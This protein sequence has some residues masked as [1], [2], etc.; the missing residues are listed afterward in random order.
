MP[1][2]YETTATVGDVASG[3]FT[4]LYNASG[5]NV[6]N[7]GGG[8]VSGNLNVAGNLTVQGTS[9]LQGAVILGSTL[10][11]P[12]YTMPS[13]DGST[14]Q[15]L[16]TDGSGNLYW[17]NVAAIPGAAYTIQ[18]DATTG[19]ANLTLLS[20]S[21]I[22]D[23]VKFAEGTNITIVQ[24]DANTIT[25]SSN[26]D[27]I[28]SG[29]A[30]GQLL[31]WNGTAWTA[32]NRISF[33]A[34]SARPA[35]INNVTGGFTAANFLKQY[36]G[37]LLDG[38]SVGTLWGATNGTTDTYTHR[39]LS[40]YDTGGNP[41]F[42]VQA[43]PVGNFNPS[44]PTVYTQLRLDNNYLGI[45]GTELVLLNNHTGTPT[46][47]GVIRVRRGS[48]TDATI[49]WDENA[50]TW[51]FSA[52]I[53]V[54]G[55]I[56]ADGDNIYINAD[57]TAIDSAVNFNAT[58]SL[59][60][61][62]T[63][64]QFVL[65]NDLFAQGDLT[66]TGQN[67]TVNVDN[68]AA[69][70]YLN[71]GFGPSKKYLMLNNTTGGFDINNNLRLTGT[72]TLDVQGDT[73]LVGETGGPTGTSFLQFGGPFQYIKWDGAGTH[74]DVSH[75]LK[76]YADLEA[77]G[78]VYVNVDD[79]AADSYLYMKGT[80]KYI[81]WDNT[82]N[83]FEI[84]GG[85]IATG[86]ENVYLNTDNNAV[87]TNIYFNT[88]EYLR[89]SDSNNRFEFSDGI[90]VGGDLTADSITVDGGVSSFNSQTTTTTSTAT[91]QISSTTKKS[92]KV[93]I[94][95]TDNVTTEVHAVE[96]LAMLK[97]T[98]AYL[99][100][101]GEMYSASALATF[102]ADVSAGSLRILATPASSNSTTFQVSRI[103]LGI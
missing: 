43:D 89:W 90:Y 72:S 56:Y 23:S 50:D 6:P 98:T 46:Q 9:L 44:S 11:L 57:N 42:R 54:N 87:D 103:S 16:V 101:Y 25:I 76:S 45:V 37:S 77:Q 1:S 83:R 63:G 29:T 27:D 75:T 17:Q 36:S 73:I 60:W 88:T 84:Y 24:T 48:S 49:T 81:R 40:E 30:Q 39:V 31:Y 59:K 102:T 38:T 66:G 78:N 64:G 70:A 58:E 7:A 4:T 32:N 3:N 51:G 15:V 80:S 13:G 74:F 85:D 34:N 62:N 92:Q 86:W 67:I 33:I 2:L 94:Y 52:A 28:P 5:L 21:S 97:G 53:A 10:T 99:T 95:I 8:S 47:N 41:I 93:V 18:A 82:L 12:N 61:D 35:F 69:D 19:G 14:D 79:T 55:N 68:T 96:A 20:S 22:A 71:F 65:S 100:T 91:V 26:A